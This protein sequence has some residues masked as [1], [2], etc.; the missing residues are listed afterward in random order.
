MPAA[1]IVGAVTRVEVPGKIHRR[2]LADLARHQQL[3]DRL[4][5]RRVAVIEGDDQ[6]AAALLFGVEHRLALLLVDDHR[7]FGHHVD[8]A[9]ERL[10]DVLAVEAV[11][12]R[13]HQQIGLRLVHHLDRN[14]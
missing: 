1:E 7:L 9:F 14:R 5:L 13:D 2:H 6:V 8:A 4:V 10:D 3:F 11:D 12:R